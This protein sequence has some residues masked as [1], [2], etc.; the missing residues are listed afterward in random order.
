M[1][2]AQPPCNQSAAQLHNVVVACIHGIQNRLK[3]RCTGVP[4]PIYRYI[5]IYI[6]LYSNPTATQHP[7]CGMMTSR[8]STGEDLLIWSGD[9]KTI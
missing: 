8:V 2:P 3:A 9:M 1:G 4:T 5:D 6:H 7:A